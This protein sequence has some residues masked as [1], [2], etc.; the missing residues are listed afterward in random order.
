MK[1]HS[2]CVDAGARCVCFVTGTRAAGSSLSPTPRLFLLKSAEATGNKRVR[3]HATAKEWHKSAQ[4]AENRT[5]HFCCL[6]RKS[7]EYWRAAVLPGSSMPNS[8]D[9][10]KG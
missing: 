1:R 2:D 8:I 3:L 5:V 6:D 10:F 7:A 4:V 9:N